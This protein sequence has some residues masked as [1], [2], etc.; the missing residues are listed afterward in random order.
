[1]ALAARAERHGIEMSDRVTAYLPRYA[2]ILSRVAWLAGLR[3][4]IPGAARVAER[5][6]GM[7]S[8]RALPRWQGDFLRQCVPAATSAATAAKEVLL[9]VDTFTNYFAH[10]NAR[11]ARLVLETA[12]YIVH[13]NAIPGARPL[14]CGRTFLSAGLVDDA[15]SEARRAL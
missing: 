5:W 4:R 15:K 2:P 3:D 9:F 13:T 12:G 7:S 10:E 11:A 8:R 6:L 14:C 1:E